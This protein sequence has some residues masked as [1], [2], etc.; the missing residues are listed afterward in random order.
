MLFV[1]GL[2]LVP[3]ASRNALARWLM[4]WMQTERYTF[5]QLEKLPDEIVVPFAEPFTVTAKLSEKTEWS[6]DAGAAR[7]GKQDPV[8]TDLSGGSY[9]FPMPP[10][11]A[12]ED[13]VLAIGDARR[14][15]PLSP[16]LV[17]S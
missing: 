12:P 7:Y 16:P 8:R 11:K 17:Q 13:L 10:Q 3:A 9:E 2:I 5:A 6:P 4:P 1:V 14:R 15:S